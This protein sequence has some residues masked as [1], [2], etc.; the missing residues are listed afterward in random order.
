MAKALRVAVVGAGAIGGYY[1]GK[2]ALAGSEVHFLIRGDLAELRRAGLH[3][4]GRDENIHVTDINYHNDTVE[5]GPCDL[6][7]IAVKAISN[8][9][10]LPVIPPLL[11]PETILMTLQNGLGNEEFFAAR[12]GEQRV[13][14][15]LC[16]ICLNRKSPTLIEHY[17]YGRISVGEYQ[18]KP[19]LRTLAIVERLNRA[20]VSARIVEDL[21]LERW[22]KLVWNIPF[23]AI[24]VVEGGIDTAQILADTTLRQRVVA[25]MHEVIVGAN[26]CGHALSNSEATEQMRRTETMDAY[27]PSTLVDWQA[28]KPLEL[29]AIWGEPLRRARAGG[30]EMPLLARLY[31]Q[32]KRMDE[33]RQVGEVA[34]VDGIP[35]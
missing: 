8:A 12:F 10:I 35:T 27:K 31:E 9:N 11:H 21:A 32:L 3:I 15:G 5:I 7:L 4:V 30:A 29:E 6:V 18:R 28:G 14:G 22:R 23:N 25:L 34:N 26:Q 2:L 17:D 33:A 13:L 16:F 20:N 19:L 24:S 1:G